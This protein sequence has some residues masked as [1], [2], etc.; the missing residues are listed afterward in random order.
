MN[1]ALPRPFNILL[2]EDAPGDIRLMSEAF[3]KSTLETRL[4]V[5]RDGQEAVAFLS[6]E[7]PKPD[8]IL[9]DL[10]IP[11]VDGFELL[12]RIKGEP[13]WKAIPVVILTA[14]NS[15]EDIQKAYDLFANCY[16]LKPGELDEFFQVVRSI[17]DFWL[18]LV[19]LPSF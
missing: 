9:L 19:Q 13:R 5:A 1:P 17:Q 7:S 16:L 8:L 3:K 11:K 10:S 4:H 18:S 14:S 12:G 2:V 15:K 6:A